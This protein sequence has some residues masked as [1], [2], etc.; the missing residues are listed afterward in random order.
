MPTQRYRCLKLCG[1]F[2]FSFDNYQKEGRR[3]KEEGRRKMKDDERE[4][5]GELPITNY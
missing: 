3:K 5:C 2:H 1:E 4:R